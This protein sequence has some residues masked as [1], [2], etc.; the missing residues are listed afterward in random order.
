ML[1]YLYNIFKI[2][3]IIHL[4]IITLK[5]QNLCFEIKAYFLIETKKIGI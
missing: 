4:F 3:G 1:V 2:V 5:I